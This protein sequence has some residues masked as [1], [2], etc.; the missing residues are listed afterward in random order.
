MSEGLQCNNIAAMVERDVS[1][2]A[3]SAM[4]KRS[5]GA[6]PSRFFV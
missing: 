5:V 1:V 2:S 3:F 6:P 4:V